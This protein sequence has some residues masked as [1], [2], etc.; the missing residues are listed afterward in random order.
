MTVIVLVILI[1]IAMVM[2]GS[3]ATLVGWG[4]FVGAGGFFLLAAMASDGG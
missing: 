4:M 3:S 2:V 1:G